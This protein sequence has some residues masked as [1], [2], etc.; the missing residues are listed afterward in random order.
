MLSGVCRLIANHRSS[1]SSK[2]HQKSGSFPPLALPSLNGTMTLS[3]SRPGP[4]PH[5]TLKTLPPPLTGI[6]RLPETPFDVPCPLPRWTEMGA[7]IGCF[8]IPRGL[9]RN[10]GGS[11]STS[12]LSR[13]AQASLALRPARS[14]DRPRRPSSRGFGQV[15]RPTKPLVSYRSLPTTLRVEPSSTGVPRRRGALNDPG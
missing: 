12:S 2:A 8:P 14:L 1:P 11:A 13:P 15:G 9:P 3:D 7:R 5:A 4:P 10:S 6:P